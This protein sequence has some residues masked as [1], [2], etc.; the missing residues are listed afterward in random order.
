MASLRL[1]A[2][3]AVPA[4]AR[5]FA[6][7]QHASI[8]TKRSYPCWPTTFQTEIRTSMAQ[9]FDS[10]SGGKG[11][12]GASGCTPTGGGAA[13]ATVHVILHVLILHVLILHTRHVIGCKAISDFDSRKSWWSQYG[14]KTEAW[15]QPNLAASSVSRPGAYMPRVCLWK[16]IFT[17]G[18]VG[19]VF[20][21]QD[22]LE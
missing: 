14:C 20:E 3:G 4:S 17:L 18:N 9:G 6:H 10:A 11:G 21:R 12:R 15:E 16:V 22:G 7:C 8:S 19:M 1:G 13:E 2:E 5:S